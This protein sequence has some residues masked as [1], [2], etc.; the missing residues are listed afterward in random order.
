VAEIVEAE[1][2]VPSF[3]LERRRLAASSR[4]AWALRPRYVAMRLRGAWTFLRQR[5]VARRG[6]IW[7]A[8]GAEVRC[9]KGLGHM[10]IGRDAWLGRETV[11]RCHEGS[12]RIGDDVTF[13]ARVTVNAYLDVEIGDDCLFAD[14]VYVG[15]FDHRF[16]SLDAPIRSQGIEAAPVRIGRDCWIGRGA[17]ILRGVHV[18][19]G[20]VVGANAVVTRDVPARSIVVGAPARVVGTRG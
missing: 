10:E 6:A 7:L 15:D 3:E 16:E 14:D 5:H 19:A 11:L 20:A 12:M 1:L 13:G 17:T 4:G 2:S 9:R 8:R 18:G